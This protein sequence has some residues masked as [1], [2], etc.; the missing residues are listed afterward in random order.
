MRRKSLDDLSVWEL[1]ELIQQRRAWSRRS[2]SFSKL[3]MSRPK[4]SPTSHNGRDW[5]KKALLLTETLVIVGLLLT[6]SVSVRGWLAL[7]QKLPTDGVTFIGE[8]SPATSPTETLGPT[9][10]PPIGWRNSQLDGQTAPSGAEIVNQAP[11]IPEHLKGWIQP[12]KRVISVAI[13]E[14]VAQPGTRI[15]I[16]SINVDAPIDEGTDWESL[17]FKVGH[18]PDTANPGERGNMVLAAHNDVYGEIFRYLPDVPIGE[19]VMVYAGEQI[20]RYRITQRQFILPKQAEVMLPT[21]GPTLTLIS[22]YPY[23]IDTHRIIL[24]GELVG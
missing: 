19:I 2:A 23:L 12:A 24:S 5:W 7:R 8:Q 17:K 18:H 9:P 11:E 3:V 4:S 16:P 10:I 21:T 15:V 22:C 20:F 6:F 13:P 1:E 14:P